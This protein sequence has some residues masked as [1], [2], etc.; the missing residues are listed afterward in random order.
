[1]APDGDNWFRVDNFSAHV[2]SGDDGSVIVSLAGEFDLSTAE[3]LRETLVR[4]EVL[5]AP[6]VRID[7]SGLTFLDSTGIGLLV[8]ACKR[9]RNAG[10]TF[11]VNCGL[12]PVPRQVLEAAGLIE[13]LDVEDAV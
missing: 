4:S 11:S 12:G 13:Y 2:T 8:A 7:L 5:D 10:G 3:D 1:M 9:V 6:Q